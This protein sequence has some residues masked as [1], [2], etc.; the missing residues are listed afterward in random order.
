MPKATH[1]NVTGTPLYAKRARNDSDATTRL[2][3]QRREVQEVLE[4]WIG[5]RDESLDHQFVEAYSHH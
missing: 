3:V 1:A 2:R 4:R 5:S